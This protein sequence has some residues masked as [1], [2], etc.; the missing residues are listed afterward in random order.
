MIEKLCKEHLDL[1]T[2]E[3][4]LLKNIESTMHYTANLVGS[5]LFID[6]LCRS[7]NKA[8]VVAE[9]KPTAEFSIYETSVVGKDVYPEN[10]PAVF[11]VF[12]SGMPV[13]DIRAVTQE[14]KIVKQDVVPIKNKMDKVF[15]VLI[16][17]KDI[18]E[19]FQRD[20]KYEELVHTTEHLSEMLFKYDSDKAVYIPS[21]DENKLAMKEIHHRIKNNLQMIASI[22]NLQVRRSRHTEIKRIFK[23]NI[24]RILSIASIHDILTQ[25]GLEEQISIKEIIL[26]IIENIKKY[27]ESSDKSIEI[28]VE[29]DDF[30]V[31]SNVGTSIA[32][33]TNELVSNAVEHAFINHT[34]GMVIVDINYGNQYSSVTVSDNGEGFQVPKSSEENDNISNIGLDLVRLIVYNKLQGKIQFLTSDSGSKVKFDFKN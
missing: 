14:N 21:V 15:A 32:I 20:K 12:Y 11:N 28:T 9:A 8:I 5:D 16:R 30:T 29:G 34:K 31:C 18:S 4:E 19:S 22:L 13:R 1:T 26:K 23:E 3:I 24:S 10:E 2:D 7:E 6:C 27:S 25:N 33:V 17:E